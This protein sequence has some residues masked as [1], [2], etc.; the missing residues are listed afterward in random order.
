MLFSRKLYK[1]IYSSIGV[2][3]T[4]LNGTP[5]EREPSYK[6]L[7]FWLDD[8]LSLNPPPPKK[9]I[10]NEL[11]KSWWMETL[12]LAASLLKSM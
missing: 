6:H 1:T 12:L 11:T 10:I 2:N 5:I 7:D 4:T 8:K 9:K 3:I